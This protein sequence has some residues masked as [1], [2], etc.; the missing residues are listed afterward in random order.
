MGLSRFSDLPTCQNLPIS[1]IQSPPVLSR[2]LRKYIYDN[3][4]YVSSTFVNNKRNWQSKRYPAYLT[5]STFVIFRLTS[6][7]LEEDGV[8]CSLRSHFVDKLGPEGDIHC[9]YS[10]RTDPPLRDHVRKHLTHMIKATNPHNMVGICSGL[11][12]FSIV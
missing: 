3:L 2:S 12:S 6:N 5:K 8:A 9:L 7:S 10:M 1:V 4:C 11:R